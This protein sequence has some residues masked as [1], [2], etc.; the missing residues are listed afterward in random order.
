MR[1]GWPE[2]AMNPNNLFQVENPKP[3]CVGTG[4]ITL[5]IVMNQKGISE[6]RYWAGGSCG[7]V[8]T[9][10][11]Y[12]G[13]DSCPVAKLGNDAAGKYLINDME[14]WGVNCSHV[15]L[16]DSINT[17]IIVEVLS[18]GRSGKPSHRWKWSCPNCGSRLPSYKP[19]PFKE[20]N[21]IDKEMLNANVFYFDRVA[22][23]N[24]ELAKISKTYGAIV[25]F[26]P[27]RI[28]NKGI[29]KECVEIADIVKYSRDK[30]GYFKET[31]GRTQV[32]IE[33]ETLGDEGIR[34]RRGK[35]TRD[36]EWETMP[37]YHIGNGIRDTAGSGDW[38]SVGIIHALCRCGRE[39]F[40]SLTHKDIK[41][42]INFGQ[43]LA[44][45][46]CYYTGARGLMYNVSKEKL[47]TLIQ[48]IW[49][50]KNV[51]LV[52][53]EEKSLTRPALSKIGCANCMNSNTSI[54]TI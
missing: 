8:L 45:A 54:Q 33:I 22:R 21:E 37:A 19:F 17:P 11:S 50:G 25:V 26:E 43:A 35:D 2:S 23:S 24:V 20:I 40:E 16:S 7:N 18:N 53:E 29:F 30:Y 36:K 38:C 14:T 42:A 27:S 31:L 28:R 41:S 6:S 15:Y 34:F 47:T 49:D 46:K 48:D 9:I 3:R 32:P 1:F 10:L 39:H 51:V 52:A 13:W 44:A 4:L 12:I 5:D